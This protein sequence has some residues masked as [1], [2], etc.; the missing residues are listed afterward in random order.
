M[1]VGGDADFNVTE[2]ASLGLDGLGYVFARGLSGGFLV[3]SQAGG[4]NQR[5]V[6]AVVL[7][8]DLTHLN[9][10]VAD[11]VGPVARSPLRDVHGFQRI[12]PGVPVNFAAGERNPGHGF[13]LFGDLDGD[14][15]ITEVLA[16]PDDL[17]A[18]L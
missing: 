2:L 13:Q 18:Y 6:Q 10:L 12:F 15:I 8:A 4:Q 5:L 1:V 7:L 16:R 17:M 3:A 9:V 14:G 11:G